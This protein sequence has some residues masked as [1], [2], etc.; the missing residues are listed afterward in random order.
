MIQ[1]SKDENSREEGFH[2]YYYQFGIKE[3]K[4]I[5]HN[6]NLDLNMIQFII[7]IARH[8]LIAF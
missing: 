5:N 7:I 2:I 1:I 8:Y 3:K 4:K 6:F